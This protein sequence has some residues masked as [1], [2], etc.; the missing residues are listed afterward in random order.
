MFG[1]A[2]ITLGIGPHSSFICTV[3]SLQF[4]G[5]DRIFSRPTWV[6]RHWRGSASLDFNE[7]R[8]D[9]VAVASAGLYANH[10]HLRDVAMATTF[11]LWMG[12]NF[13]CMIANDMLF[14]SRGGF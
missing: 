10:L 9:E 5:I 8:D 6:S 14:D 11:W 2:T 7:A 3:C 4:T 12:Y 1:R 13:G